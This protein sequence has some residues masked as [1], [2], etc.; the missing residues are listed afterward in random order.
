AAVVVATV[1]LFTLCFSYF[2][3][4]KTRKL[5]WVGIAIGLAGIILLN[6]GGNLSGNPWGAIL[7]L[8]GSMSWAFGSVYGSRIALPVGMMAGAIEMLAA[9]VV[10]LCAAFLSGEK[11]AT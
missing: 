8:I 10:L 6:S 11:L 7:I 1:P 2:F 3:G 5:E 4:I 9:G